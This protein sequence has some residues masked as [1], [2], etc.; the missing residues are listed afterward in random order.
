VLSLPSIIGNSFFILGALC[1]YNEYLRCGWASGIFMVLGVIG[2]PFVLYATIKH[3][4]WRI[5]A[6]ALA[7]IVP[8]LTIVAYA[9][10]AK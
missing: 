10:I 3:W 4:D 8:P 7:A 5:M 2:W 9:N 1:F 6:I